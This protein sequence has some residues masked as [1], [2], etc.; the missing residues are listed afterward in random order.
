MAQIDGQSMYDLKQ[1]CSETNN[2]FVDSIS[3][4]MCFRTDRSYLAGN[5]F[6]GGLCPIN[7]VVVAAKGGSFMPS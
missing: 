1:A 3:W 4:A 6:G 7:L 2:L 5:V